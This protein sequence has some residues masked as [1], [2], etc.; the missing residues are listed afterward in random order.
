MPMIRTKK[1]I[2]KGILLLLKTDKPVCYRA[3]EFR[4]IGYGTA[5]HLSD[6]LADI[7]FC[8]RVSV[9]LGIK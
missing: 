2:K 8:N 3:A 9:T 6:L 5:N 1:D 4:Q 7:L